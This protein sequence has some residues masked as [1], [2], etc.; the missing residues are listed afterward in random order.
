MRQVR[1]LF[2]RSGV[3][4]ERLQELCRKATTSEHFK[5][6]L[7]FTR[8][9]FTAWTDSVREAWERHLW[10]RFFL[11]DTHMPRWACA[12]AF[13]RVR[14]KYIEIFRES[15]AGSHVSLRIQQIFKAHGQKIELRNG[16]V[17]ASLA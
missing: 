10:K 11:I 8:G 14:E 6:L 5:L 12:E 15:W 2:R 4:Y 17:F 1:R 16:C 3:S 13:V 9:C 7:E